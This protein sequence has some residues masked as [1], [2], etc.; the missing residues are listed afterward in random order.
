MSV[1]RHSHSEPVSEDPVVVYDLMREAATRLKSVY[2]AQMRDGDRE[3]ALARISALKA[4]V[5]AVGTRDVAAQWEAQRSFVE[6]YESA[7]AD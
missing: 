4:E 6:R 1:A 3:D 5:R 7:I 2:V